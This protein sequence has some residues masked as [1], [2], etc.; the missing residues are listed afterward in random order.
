MMFGYL[1]PLGSRSEH[2]LLEGVLNQKPSTTWHPTRS[3][4]VVITQLQEL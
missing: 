3:R 4:Y 1:D 2:Q